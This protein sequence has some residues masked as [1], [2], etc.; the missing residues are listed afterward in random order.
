MTGAIKSRSDLEEG[1]FRLSNPRFTDESIEKNLK[2]VEVID[3]IASSKGVTKAQIALAWILSRNDKIITIPG[4]R[5]IHRL[6]ENFGALHTVITENDLAI[7]EK[8]LPSVT[9]GSR[10]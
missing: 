9:S 5:K 10:Y 3:H 8:H 2:F 6:E 4:T 1:D 7:I